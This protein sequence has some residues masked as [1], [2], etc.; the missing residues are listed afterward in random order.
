MDVDA[1]KTFIEVNRT[2]H[3]GQAAENLY[4]SQS[5]VSARIRMLE[6]EV[7]VP[8]FTRQRNNIQLTAAG[9]RLLQYADNIL[10]TWYRAKQEIGTND[11]SQIPFTIGSMPSLWDLTLKSWIDYMQET[12]PDLILHAEINDTSM[13]LRRVRESTMD[14]AFC[15]DYPQTEDVEIVEIMQ[16]PLILVSSEADLTVEQA[17]SSNYMLVDWG[18][19]FAN[20]HAQH[21]AGMPAAHMRLALGRMAKDLILSHGGSA[22]L[23]EP[24]V[25]E[26]LRKKKLFRVKTAPEIKRGAIAAYSRETEKTATI[27]HALK[28]FEET[29]VQT[30]QAV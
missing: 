6:Q 16:I 5:A 29:R 18:T 30:V 10:T 3:F 19:S 22:Y 17:L 8:L 20:A 15:F 26:E 11:T 12:L 24:M 28:F 13:L 7:G 1:L 2:R 9:Q 21:F 25:R 27:R 4:L 23:G 14:L